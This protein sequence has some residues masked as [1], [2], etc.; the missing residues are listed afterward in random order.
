MV[1]VSSG[2][3]AAPSFLDE[4]YYCT[5]MVSKKT[6]C[7]V[8]DKSVKNSSC[9]HMSLNRRPP[10]PYTHTP[11]P[12]SSSFSS[13]RLQKARP[14]AEGGERER[15][16]LLSRGA[17]QRHGCCVHTGGGAACAAALRRCCCFSEYG[18]C[19]NARDSESNEYAVEASPCC[20]RPRGGLPLHRCHVHRRRLR[21]CRRPAPRHA[22]R[23]PAK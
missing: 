21:R 12:S 10:P 9:G 16:L 4:C 11:L 2:W 13:P 19:Y 20:R 23:A 5:F 14:K 22:P 15:E 8:A 6:V 1:C 7:V 3:V 18:W 17:A